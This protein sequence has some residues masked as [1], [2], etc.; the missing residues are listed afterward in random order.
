MA[1]YPDNLEAGRHRDLAGRG[2]QVWVRRV[3]LVA[4][5]AMAVAGLL[6]VF[7]QRSISSQAAGSGAAIE[8]RGPTKVRGGLLFQE[9]ITVHALR[10]IAYPRLVLSQGWLDGLQINTIEPQPMSESSRNGRLVLSYDKLMAGDKIEV[11]IDFQV[12]PTHVGR[13]D[14]TVELD[15]RAQPLVRLARSLTTFP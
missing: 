7:G 1:G 12:N 14:Q 4:F 11:F 10:D 9:R 3:V 15:D 13:T 2:H 6:N 8:V 5:L